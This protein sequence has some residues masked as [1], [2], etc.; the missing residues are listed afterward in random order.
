MK[1]I[2]LLF[3]VFVTMLNTLFAQTIY[4]VMDRNDLSIT[5][6]EKFA[7]E[8]FKRVGTERGSGYKQYQRWLYE[9]KFNVDSKGFIISKE[10]QMRNYKSFSSSQSTRAALNLNWT[11]LGPNSWSRTTGWNP[12]VGRLS[13]IA[14]DKNN[15][16]LIFV[17]SPGGGIWKTTNGGTNWQ[18]LTDN[19]AAWMNIYALAIDP[20]NSNIIYAGTTNIMIKSIDGGNTWSQVGT[21]NFGAKKILIHPTNSNIIYSAGSG[22]LYV[23]NDAGTTWVR[24]LTN[25]VEDVEFQPNNTSIMMASGQSVFRS[26]NSGNTWTALTSTQGI[27][28]TGRTMLAISPANTQLVYAVQANGNTFGRMYKSIDGGASFTTTVIGNS[29]NGTNYFGYSVVGTDNSGQATYDMAICA[30]PTNANEVHIAGIICWKSTNGGNSFVAETE[31]SL[32]NAT[33]YNHADVHQLEWINNTIYSTSDGG[34]YKSTDFGDNWIDLSTG[35]GIRQFYRIATSDASATLITGGAQDNGSSVLTTNGWRDW[36]GA[37]GMEGLV[38]PTNPAKLWGTSQNGL[39]YRS[40]DGGQTR[41]TLGQPSGGNWVTPIVIHPTNDNILYG[42]W[43]GIYKSTNGG[44]SWT[45]VASSTVA[46]AVT[47]MAIAPSN[48]DYVYATYNGASNPRFFATT[49]GGATWSNLTQP[50]PA[51]YDLCVSPLNPNKV[52]I[53]GNGTNTGRVLFSTNAGVSFTDIS[54][55]LPNGLGVRAIIVDNTV[56]E[57]IYV[58]TNVGVFY[59]DNLNTNWIN[60]TGN[61]P[62]VA[63][64][65]LDINNSAGKLRA[66]TYGRGVWEINIETSSTVCLPPLSLTTTNITE[67]DATLSWAAVSGAANYIVEYKTASSQLWTIL[68]ATQQIT[69]TINNLIPNTSYN[70]RVKTNCTSLSSIYTSAN[71]STLIPPCAEPQTLTTTNIT[72]NTATLN[73]AAISGITDYTVEYK[74]QSDFSWTSAGNTTNNFIDITNLVIGSDYAWRVKTNCTYSSSIYSV[75]EFTTS[76]TTCTAP[77]YVYTYLNRDTILVSWTPVPGVVNYHVQL[78]EA[79]NSWNTPDIDDYTIDTFYLLT[80]VAPGYAIDWRVQSNCGLNTSIF[81]GASF[82]TPCPDPI[83]LSSTNITQTG[84]TVNWTAGATGLSV[85]LEYKAASSNTWIL[86]NNAN[87][88]QTYT[89]SALTPGTTYDWR[90]KQNCYYQNTSNYVSAQFTTVSN[91]CNAATGLNATAITNNSA[92]LNWTASLN[93][94]SYTIRYKAATSNSWITIGS[95]NLLTIN[96][97]NTLIA[98]TLYDFEVTTNCGNTSSPAIVAQFTTLANPCNAPT[99]LTTTNITSTTATLNWVG[100]GQGSYTIEYKPVSATTWLSPGSTFLTSVATSLLIPNTLYEWR[101]FTNCTN[102]QSNYASAQFTTL[103]AA[104]NA[105]SSITAAQVTTTSIGVNWFTVQGATSYNLQYKLSSATTWSSINNLNVVNY[106]IQG[107]QAGATYDIRVQAVC[108]SGTSNFVNTSFTLNVIYCTSNGVNNNEWI[109]L[110][111]VGTINRSSSAEAGGYVNTGLTTDLII[112]SSNA[113]QVSNGHT[114]NFKQQ[115]YAVFIDFNRN[116]SFN[117]AGDRVAGVS[118]VIN[119]GNVN[120]NINI[121]TTAT[122]GPVK[123]R[124]VMN[125]K[126]ASI[127]ACNTGNKGETEDYIINL[128]APSQAPILNNESIVVDK[129]IVSPNPTKGLANIQIPN[130]YENGTIEVLNNMGKVVIRKSINAQTLIQLDLGMLSN[131]LYFLKAINNQG[132]NTIVK[133]IKL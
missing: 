63:I 102:T 118:L 47:D 34:I 35:L 1:K 101:V 14:V 92:I 107:L 97:P 132:K 18:P 119:S 94:V 38:S 33:G 83:N 108:G 25:S 64:N 89:F 110:F 112:G 48:G 96:T 39:L 13:A 42:G 53:A 11:E 133:I 127:T 15:E 82:V 114:G 55:N 54:G 78:K 6:V 51:I 30:S 99:G 123:L 116:G 104:C 88:I 74:L 23:S 113:A 122:P 80:G 49:D 9:R 90:I 128:V 57:G 129:V 20:Q 95:T 3:I 52:F 36:L 81:K 117:D 65:E 105:P 72:N 124:V 85:R 4:E 43:T 21:T 75:A 31:W 131:N 62:L 28:N 37:D 41:T 10:T 84:A 22:G 27:T 50:V 120:F 19:N 24:T 91:A 12:G 125:R 17:G 106:T 130:G 70:W 45:N 68:P 2:S 93:A 16:Q 60:Y 77:N 79:F 76:G 109:D 44:V 73:W 115:N 40:L 87:S 103:Q 29:A 71:F 100:N 98:N 121:P 46:V 58:G 66:A 69:T 67:T 86:V 111:K 59:R 7:N 32:P 61:L 8:Y 126:P 56:N 26:T 5:Q